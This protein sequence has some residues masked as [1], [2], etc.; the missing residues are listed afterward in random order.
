MK[1]SLV[2]ALLMAIILPSTLFGQSAN[3]QSADPFR[4]GFA[5]KFAE[6]EKNNATAVT[7]AD[8]WLFLS[9]ECRLLSVGPFWGEDAA[10]VSRSPKP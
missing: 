1:P 7:G 5:Q 3:A 10:K 2:F 9:A 4:S 8:G 6:A